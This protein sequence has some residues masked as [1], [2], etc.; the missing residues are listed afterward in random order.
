MSLTRSNKNEMKMNCHAQTL[1]EAGQQ[2][3]V[4]GQRIALSG[5]QMADVV[6]PQIVSAEKEIM[7][8]Q[9]K[10]TLI[11]VIVTGVAAVGAVAVTQLPQ[12]GDSSDAVS[13][14]IPFLSKSLG[15]FRAWK[16]LRQSE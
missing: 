11:G 5:R 14:S 9:D 7:A 10:V 2:A 12:E 4:V 3:M 15:S 6:V 13:S 16:F 8:D 1:G